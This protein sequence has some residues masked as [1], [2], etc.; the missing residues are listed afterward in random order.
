MPSTNESGRSIVIKLGDFL[1][2]LY[3]PKDRFKTI[4]ATI[5]QRRF[6]PNIVVS[7]NAASGRIHGESDSRIGETALA[8]WVAFPH[9]LRVE[10]NS[11]GKGERDECLIVQNGGRVWTRS[12]DGHVEASNGQSPSRLI[13]VQRHFCHET[14]REIFVCLAL[15][16][17]GTVKTLGYDC[18]QVRA[19]PRHGAILWPHWL[20]TSAEEYELYAEPSMGILL[21]VFARRNGE[22]FEADEVTHLVVDEPVG[23]ERFI[24]TPEPGVQIAEAGPRVL[25]LTLEAAVK[26]AGFA[27]FVPAEMPNSDN[28]QLE[29][30]YYPPHRQSPRCYL[31]LSYR[32]NDSSDSLLVTESDVRDPELDQHEWERAQLGAIEV[33]IARPRGHSEEHLVTLERE[34]THIAIWSNLDRKRLLQLAVSLCPAPDEFRNQ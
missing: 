2:T 16:A 32:W 12:R 8:V 18:I 22:V 1:E 23:D 5:R 17:V 33:Q 20:P 11:Q 15:E 31:A 29:V 26:R 24:F 3:G 9:R 6:P 34:G 21:S 10:T 14:L 25:W 28:A 19:V 4:A 30:M 27:V 7:G 13:D